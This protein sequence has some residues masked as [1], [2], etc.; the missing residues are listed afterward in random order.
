LA[1][2]GET[3]RQQNRQGTPLWRDPAARD[4]DGEILRRWPGKI[5]QV[6][7]QRTGESQRIFPCPFYLQR[8]PGGDGWQEHASLFCRHAFN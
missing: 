4:T 6:K 3:L 7:G 8:Q 5:S 2:G 1:A